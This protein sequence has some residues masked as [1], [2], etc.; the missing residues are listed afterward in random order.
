MDGAKR[1]GV[2]SDS[3]GDQDALD[4]L[5]EKMGR[6]DAACFLGDVARD[7]DYLRD[8]LFERPNHPTLYAVRGNNDYYSFCTAPWSLEI[9]LF[10][11]R[12]HMEHGHRCPSLSTLCYRAQEAGARVAMF[13]HTHQAL[14]QWEQGVLLLNPGSAGNYCRGGRARACVLEIGAAGEL[15]VINYAL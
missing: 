12:I 14:C 15:R 2:F 10:G 6:L 5:M 3:H 1:V 9:E 13:G 8:R 11:V 4:A 7:G